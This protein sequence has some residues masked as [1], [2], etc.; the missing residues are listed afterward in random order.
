MLVI[1]SQFSRELL[2]KRIDLESDFVAVL[3]AVLEGLLITFVVLGRGSSSITSG[4]VL[5]PLKEKSSGGT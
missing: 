1:P 2:F 3:S 4:K 5:T